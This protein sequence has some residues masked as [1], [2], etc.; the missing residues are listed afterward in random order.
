M[1][2]CF[3]LFFVNQQDLANAFEKICQSNLGNMKSL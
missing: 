3:Q 2:N 1:K